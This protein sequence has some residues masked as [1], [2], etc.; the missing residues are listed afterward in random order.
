MQS[1][2][3]WLKAQNVDPDTII[4]RIKFDTKESHPKLFFKAMRYLNDEE[5][6]V[7]EDKAAS[8]DAKQA[9]L[10]NPAQVDGV[11]PKPKF[12]DDAFVEPPKAKAIPKV[13]P[14][15][16][17]EP[18]AP[19]AKRG[20]P[21]KTEAAPAEED[22]VEPTVRKAPEAPTIPTRPPLADTIASWDT[23]D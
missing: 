19:A 21:K 2:A 12:E 4:T 8:E 15:E 23:D 18:P 3:R 14:E 11:A 6:G 5:F 22:E 1:Y 10:L 13:E 9:V 17:D 16:E 20:R 7:V